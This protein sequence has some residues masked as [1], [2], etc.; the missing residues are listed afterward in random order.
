MHISNY[1][2]REALQQVIKLRYSNEDDEVLIMIES[3]RNVADFAENKFCSI[4]SKSP[5]KY[6]K[7]AI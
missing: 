6:H 1:A 7:R 5:Q 3:G 2:E 4:S